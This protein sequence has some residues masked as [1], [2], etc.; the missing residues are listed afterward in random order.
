[1]ILNSEKFRN[2]QTYLEYTAVI[3]NSSGPSVVIPTTIVRLLHHCEQFQAYKPCLSHI[4]P[5]WAKVLNKRNTSRAVLVFV[6]CFQHMLL[7]A[8]LSLHQT[9]HVTSAPVV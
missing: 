7:H 5:S 1:M 9:I 4:Y 2:I 8:N 6:L 3:I